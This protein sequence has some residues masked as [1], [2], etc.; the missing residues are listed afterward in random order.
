LKTELR[1]EVCGLAGLKAVPLSPTPAL[2]TPATTP[3]SSTTAN[4]EEE[5][6]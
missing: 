6:S 5:K 4:F 1:A 3:P 2:Q